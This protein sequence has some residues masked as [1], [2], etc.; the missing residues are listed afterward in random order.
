MDEVVITLFVPQAQRLQII[1]NMTVNLNKAVGVF[2]RLKRFPNVE[3]YVC[4]E[5]KE[6]AF[7][8]NAQKYPKINVKM[9]VVHALC[10]L[11]K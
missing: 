8:Q 4:A 1:L 9:L 10:L 6:P 5:F 2:Q 7:V 3:F 11:N